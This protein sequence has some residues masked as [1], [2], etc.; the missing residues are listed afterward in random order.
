[1]EATKGE[2]GF[3]SSCFSVESVDNAVRHN[4]VQ[5]QTLTIPFVFV[6]NSLFLWVNG[7]TCYYTERLDRDVLTKNADKKGCLWC[8]VV[9]SHILF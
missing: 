5:Y 3:N 7:H 9:G 8:I 6:S 4:Y 2:V 1:M